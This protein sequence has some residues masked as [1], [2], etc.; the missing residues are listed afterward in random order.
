MKGDLCEAA[1]RLSTATFSR[2][3]THLQQRRQPQ[4]V[5]LKPGQKPVNRQMYPS[6]RSRAGRPISLLP[7]SP[8]PKR[9]GPRKA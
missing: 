7:G 3:T 5:G 8:A 6:K 2:V 9:I 1:F 4:T